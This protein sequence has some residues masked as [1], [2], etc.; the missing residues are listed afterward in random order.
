MV[1]SDSMYN[2]TAKEKWLIQ[3]LLHWHHEISCSHTIVIVLFMRKKKPKQNISDIILGTQSIKQNSLHWTGESA[4]KHFIECLL[5]A[6]YFRKYE[7]IYVK[8]ICRDCEKLRLCQGN[9]IMMVAFPFSSLTF[10][11]TLWF[12]N[13]EKYTSETAS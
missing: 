2:S 4:S 5:Y 8:N 10:K 6:S 1:C 9:G 11:N 3:G 13:T 12:H 7:M